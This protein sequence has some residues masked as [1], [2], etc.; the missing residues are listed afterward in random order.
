MYLI[1]HSENK[2]DGESCLL[3]AGCKISP[4]SRNDKWKS[5]NGRASV[6]TGAGKAPGLG[7][8]GCL[9]LLTSYA[10]PDPIFISGYD[11]FHR[12]LI[13][14]RPAVRTKLWVDHVFFF[15]LTDRLSGTFTFARA[16]GDA[17]ICNYICH[18][19]FS[20]YFYSMVF[21]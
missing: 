16:A 12:T 15:P 18:L 3:F 2:S 1:R 21:R 20:L 10:D 17:L 9:P 14:A 7:G 5:K 8:G 4:L 13:S 6:R 19:F 11:G